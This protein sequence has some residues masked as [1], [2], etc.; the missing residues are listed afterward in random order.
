MIGRKME[1]AM[2]ESAMGVIDKFVLCAWNDHA[3]FHIYFS[4]LTTFFHI[5]QKICV[6][7]L[8][9]LDNI[10]WLGIFHDPPVIW[11]CD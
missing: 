7:M 3:L 8:Q 5:D 1:T 2:A 11:N 4:T 6:R 10:M 9:M